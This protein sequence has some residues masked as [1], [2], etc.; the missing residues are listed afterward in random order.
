MFYSR[1]KTVCTSL[2]EKQFLSR[3]NKLCVPYRVVSRGY[4]VSGVF[5][6]KIRKNK[7]WFARRSFGTLNKDN[8]CNE[9][10]FGEYTVGENG[11]VTVEY[12]IGYRLPF[13]IITCIM[14][15]FGISLLTSAIIDIVDTG[16]APWGI[17][18]I[19]LL[20]VA[21]SA[22][23]ILYYPKKQVQMLLSH[24]DLICKFEH[25]KKRS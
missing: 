6:I 17:L 23:E 3:L 16:S 15:I 20:I 5:V 21:A 14:N 9:T 10:L 4:E 1:K 13:V 19:A 24:L 22:F 25:L 8:L 2:D 18:P 11:K 12:R 7:F